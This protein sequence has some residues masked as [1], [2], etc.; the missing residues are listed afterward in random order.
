MSP[1][2]PKG[3][4]MSF[5]R[6][7]IRAGC[8]LMALAAASAPARAQTTEDV[9]VEIL[10]LLVDEGVLPAEKAQ[11]L[12]DR[13][14]KN[15]ELRAQREAPVTA[16]TIDVPYVPETLRNQIRD[17]VKREVMAEA[18]AEGWVA[19]DT[20][21]DWVGRISLS[22]DFRLRYQ[23]EYYPDTNFPSFPDVNQ[24]LQDGGGSRTD[25]P[26]LNSTIDRHR[27]RYRARLAFEAQLLEQVQVG[28]RLASGDDNGAI[29]TNT[30]LGGF[31][32]K[33]DIWIDRAY[34]EWTP[35][36][37][38]SVIGGRMANPFASTDLVWDPDINPEGI[39]LAVSYPLDDLI[40]P[41]KAF[42]TGGYFPLQEREVDPGDR[43]MLAGQVGVELTPVEAVSV[44]LAGA[45]YEFKNVQGTRNPPD[46]SRL[47]DYTAP[48][49]LSQGNSLFDLRTD[50]LTSLPGLASRFELFNVTGSVGYAG[51]GDIKVTLT[52]DY[53][54]NAGFDPSEIAARRVGEPG[55]VIAEN[56]GWQ[57]RLDVGHDEIEKLGDWQV[58]AAY[59][60][61]GTDAVLDIFTDS[62]FGLGGTDVEGYVVGGRVG[63]LAN[64]S[65]GATYYSSQSINRA[66]FDVDVL[67]IDLVTS[68]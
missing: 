35:I 6:H 30:T 56:E 29:S 2:Q 48:L 13:A 45:Y 58:S 61:I 37:G 46:G 1:V 39:A 16:S 19:P 50:G 9:G 64:T 44:K 40:V 17:E 3:E 33:D 31:F 20:M 12:L 43:Y 24:I 47:N 25:F 23:G 32:D 11:T 67:Q 22:G 15:A 34:A 8:A 5:V 60:R 65:L 41:G 7:A 62:D 42:A 59:K 52:G 49:V 21:P 28:I 55:A 66:P 18:K 4:A 38:V 36:K 63:L 68:F 10:Q 51:F 14:R 57:V 27:L 53:V 54:V 26:L